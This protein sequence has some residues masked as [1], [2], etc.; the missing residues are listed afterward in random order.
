MKF[1]TFH[2]FP[3]QTP[4]APTW[5]F[6][7]GVSFCDDIDN[8]SLSKFLLERENTVKKLKS[9][10]VNGKI[11]DG[12]TGLGKNSTTSKFQ[13]YNILSWDNIELKKLK[14]N[15]CK[16]VIEYNTKH[17]NQTPPQLWI[18]CWYNVL[19]F[20]QKIKPHSHSRHPSSYLS[21]HFN[22]Q[23]NK[24]STIYMSPINQLNDPDVITIKNNV[25]EMTIFPSYIFHYTTKHY[26]LTPRITIAFDIR[27]EQPSPNWIL[28]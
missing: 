17:N 19:R 14:T 9:N 15:I 13:N 16:N 27:Y 2:S 22:V 18:Q 20:N 26:S 25:N 1:D 24:T 11:V 4:Y 23:T 5:N 12:N 21:G 8:I 10:Y 6:S 3:P 28:L 7:V